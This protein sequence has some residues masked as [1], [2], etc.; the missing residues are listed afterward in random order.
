[1]KMSLK[2]TFLLPVL[3]VVTGGLAGLVW[4]GASST[5][6][7]ARTMLKS[8][9]PIIAQ[10]VVKDVSSLVRLK[11]EALKAWG[12][13]SVVQETARGENIAD[14]QKRMAA[15]VAAMP[16]LGVDYVNLYAPN[17]DL[18]AFSL[19][20]P[21]P[22]AN[23][24]DRDY[25]QAVVSQGQENFVSKAIL[26][27]TTNKAVIIFSRAVRDAGGKVLGA[28]TA[29]VDL[30]GLTGQVSATRIGSGGHVIILEQG[31]K[32]IAH[33]D[34][35]QLLKDDV[36]KSELGQL[37]LAV[38]DQA[39]VATGDGSLAAV[40]KDP[41][42]GWTFIVAAPMADLRD[43]VRTSVNRQIWF[44][45][46]LIVVVAAAI[47]LLSMRLVTAPLSR[48]SGFAKNVAGGDLDQS[49]AVETGCREM[50]DLSQALD[51]MVAT[52]KDNLRNIA[53]KETLAQQAADKANEALSQAEESGRKACVSRQ[54]GLLEAASLL[55]DVVRGVEETATTLAE[56]LDEAVKGVRTQQD[57][58]QETASAMDQM[59][60]TIL[61]VSRNASTASEQTQ[62]V[63]DKARA[64][65][66]MV[67]SAVSAISGVDSLAGEL[68]QAMH[69]LAG[70]IRAVNQVMTVI[71]DIADQTNLLALNAAIEAARAGEAGRGFAVVADEVR[72]LAEKTMGATN[73]V[74]STINAIQSGAKTSVDKVDQVA[75]AASQAT[76]LA[77]DSGSALLEIVS[78]V[79][80]T[81]DQVRAIATAAVQ[82]SSASEHINQSVEDISQVS[83]LIA[84]GMSQSAEAMNAL[85][86]QTEALQKIIA[87]LRQA[88]IEA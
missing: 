86:S 1:M 29:T 43:Q 56:H 7:S 36:G 2:V 54:E 46:G 15:T 65:Q 39:I 14:F 13:I 27:R 17:G 85:S 61:E 47:W 84:Q 59:N 22:K 78:M 72:K 79:D 45:L 51:D 3:L 44:A 88:Q 8:D 75:Q 18:V 64:G 87:R 6:D 41:L 16:T 70:Q 10:A 49:L 82:Q 37:A 62:G 57:R 52:M 11:L 58:S 50:A 9:L 48:C 53:D 26:S 24:A 5:D 55:E 32:A 23:M 76:N 74:G 77:R 42:T 63:S 20:G 68:R 73:E 31:G 71:S 69:E 38:K 25:F 30:A 4:L 80:V 34:P 60:A 28:L 67:E 40:R 35:A 12:D 66:D 21:V 83:G 19:P 81:T 33:P